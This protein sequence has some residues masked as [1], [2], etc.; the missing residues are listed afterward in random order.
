[1][2]RCG[3]A[4][5]TVEAQMT[6]TLGRRTRPEPDVVAALVPYDPDRTSFLPADVALVV[7]VVSAESEDRD[8]R[9]KP[10]LYAEAGIRHLWRIED[11]QGLPVIHTYERD[12]TTGAYVPTG[13]HREQLKARVPFP[14]DIVPADLAR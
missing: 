12:D 3:P 6:V 7:E 1:M 13:V 14:V 4:G 2:L 8:R 11:E 5:W 10:T 9:Y